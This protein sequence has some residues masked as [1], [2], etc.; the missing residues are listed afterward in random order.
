LL[1]DIH[2]ISRK[3]NEE[4]EKLERGRW[5]GGQRQQKPRRQVKCLGYK[6]LL[7]REG[8]TSKSMLQHEN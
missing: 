4:G 6:S 8:G 7:I 1:E 5:R 2:H 3:R